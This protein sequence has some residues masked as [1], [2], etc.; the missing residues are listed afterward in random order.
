LRKGRR[1]GTLRRE[2]DGTYLNESRI[3][4]TV[5]G[6]QALGGVAGWMVKLAVLLR[7]MDDVQA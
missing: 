7:S 2:R 6:H 1:N 5:S 3:F 4:H